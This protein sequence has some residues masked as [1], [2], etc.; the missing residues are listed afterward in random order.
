LREILGMNVNRLLTAPEHLDEA[1]RL[2]QRAARGEVV[3]AICR[4]RC[5]DG[6][7]IDVQMIGVPI[8]SGGKRI[9]SFAMFE[10]ISER[11]R[12]EEARAQAEEKF[13]GLFENA[14]EGIFLTTLDG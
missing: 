12:A 14:V 2:T 13:R 3:R 4:R 6:Q 9:G 5:R 10:D 8:E 7:M 1:Q 11:V